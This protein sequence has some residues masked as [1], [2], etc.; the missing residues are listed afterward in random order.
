[1]D[2]ETFLMHYESYD[3]S[4]SFYS[5]TVMENPDFRAIVNGGTVVIPYILKQLQE[6]PSFS[7]IAALHEI[8]PSIEVPKTTCGKL[9]EVTKFWVD[10]GKQ[11]K[12]I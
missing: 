11:Q 3:S 8:K 4:T 1:M 7:L 9:N 2:Y 5:Y 6:Q 10:W 12:I